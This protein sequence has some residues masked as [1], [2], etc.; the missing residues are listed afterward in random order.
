M[1]S[2]ISA[3]AH[4]TDVL[5]YLV[6]AAT[7]TSSES[8]GLSTTFGPSLC[9]PA[10]RSTGCVIKP[11]AR[12]LINESDERHSSDGD[13]DDDPTLEIEISRERNESYDLDV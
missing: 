2:R 9:R 5:V 3:Y 11:A 6:C 4:H 7:R 10:G 8:R 1:Y 12:S 13:D